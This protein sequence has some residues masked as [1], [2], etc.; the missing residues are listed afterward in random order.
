M[1][2]LG[3]DDLLRLA[4][5][6]PVFILA[7]SIHE[8]AHAWAAWRLGDPT[9]VAQGR[10][11]LN[12]KAHLD[13]LGTIAFIIAALSGFGFGWAKAVPVNPYNLRNPNRDMALIAAAGPASN[14]LQAFFWTATLAFFA[15]LFSLFPATLRYALDPVLEFIAQVCIAGVFV[16][17]GLAA[18][19]LIPLPPLDGSRILRLFLPHEWRWRFDSLEMTGIGFILLIVLLWLG[20]L[21]VIWKPV[22]ILGR[23]LIE[24]AL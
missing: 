8:A 18:F 23:W 1:F 10:L 3:L 7:I 24:L 4:I 13:P 12:P 20:V 16:N 21:S 17:L 14:V 19:N 22:F 9:A 5:W 6:V 2:G 15:S 11:T